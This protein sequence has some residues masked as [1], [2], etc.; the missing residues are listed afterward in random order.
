MP[1]VQKARGPMFKRKAAT[2]LLLASSVSLNAL[3]DQNSIKSC[4][5]LLPEG[6]SYDVIIK[7]TIDKTSK[8]PTFEGE[9]SVNGGADNP[10]SFDIRAFVECVGPLIKHVDKKE[11]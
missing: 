7:T 10:E 8:E 9:F 11:K 1:S 5:H 2:F 4:S 6:H 3:A